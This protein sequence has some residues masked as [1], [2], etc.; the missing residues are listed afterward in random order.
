MA[1]LTATVAVAVGRAVAATVVDVAAVGR[2]AAAAVVDTAA[3]GEAT[4]ATVVDTV[5]VGKAT[6]DYIE[7]GNVIAAVLVAVAPLLK[8]KDKIITCRSGRCVKKVM[9]A[10]KT[11]KNDR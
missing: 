5:A 9:S 10:R 11:K 4:A 7:V 6:A 1:Y 3:V 8:K 2:V